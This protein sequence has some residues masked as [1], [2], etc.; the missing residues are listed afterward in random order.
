MQDVLGKKGGKT[1]A[2]YGKSFPICRGQEAQKFWFGLSANLRRLFRSFSREPEV[3]TV[4]ASCFQFRTH[5]EKN[6]FITR[7]LAAAASLMIGAVCR[8]WKQKCFWSSHCSTEN[9]KRNWRKL[10]FLGVNNALQVRE[11]SVITTNYEYHVCVPPVQGC[12][13]SSFCQVSDNLKL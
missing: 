8:E 2:D 4:V 9:R 12:Q 7:L 5:F 11:K 1:Q 10:L 3:N 13:I 6:F